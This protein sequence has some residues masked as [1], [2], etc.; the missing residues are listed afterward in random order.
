MIG[1]GTRV[2]VYDSK[3]DD[4]LPLHRQGGM[5]ARLGIDIPRSTL[6]SWT[7]SA[8]A[9]LRPIAELIRRSALTAT[10]LHCDDT[11]IPVLA[12]KTGKTKTGQY[13][14]RR[15][16]WASLSGSRSPDC[17]LLL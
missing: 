5:F 13:L 17:G 12:P 10:Y 11:K 7:G 15:P 2:R 14:G 1:P 9:E 3:Y 16:G 8:I 4:H 6:I